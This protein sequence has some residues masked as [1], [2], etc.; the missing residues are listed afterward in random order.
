MRLIIDEGNTTYCIGAGA[1]PALKTTGDHMKNIFVG[2]L[3]SGTTRE[4]IR[5]LFEPL[6]TVRNLKLMTDRDTG[7]SRGFAFVEMMEVEA[8]HAIAALDGRIV[9]GQTIE[10]REG[11]PKL[12]HG[13][14]PER[15][16]R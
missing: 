2:N 15:R 9:D 16:T 1:E 12:H 14:S 13:V 4:A 11:R 6:G 7:L 8:G 10:V 3:N 5:S